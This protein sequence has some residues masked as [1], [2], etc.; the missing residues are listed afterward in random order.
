M[1]STMRFC[2]PM[3]DELTFGTR[4]RI[5]PI[6][7]PTS[8]PIW[9]IAIANVRATGVDTRHR[10][11]SLLNRTSDGLLRPRPFKKDRLFLILAEGRLCHMLFIVRQKLL[12]AAFRHKVL[13]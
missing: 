5:S 6:M 9:T 4:F 7:E 13:T 12:S 2:G 1:L 3:R 11:C 8:P 10:Q